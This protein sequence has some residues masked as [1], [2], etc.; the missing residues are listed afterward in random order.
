MLAAV[1]V[2]FYTIIGSVTEIP[3]RATKFSR[4]VFFSP[5]FSIFLQRVY[6]YAINV[7]NYNLFRE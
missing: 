5:F 6:I 3:V 7:K 2:S 1:K 4:P